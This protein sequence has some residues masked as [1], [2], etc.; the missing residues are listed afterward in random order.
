VARKH[1]EEG[2]A[3]ITLALTH[4]QAGWLIDEARRRNVGSPSV[5]A[6]EVFDA[7]LARRRRGQGDAKARQPRRPRVLGFR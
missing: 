3:V 5:V 1:V 2:R 4:E 7:E 6:R